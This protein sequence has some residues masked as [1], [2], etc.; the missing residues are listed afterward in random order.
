MT[1]QIQYRFALV[2]L[3]VQMIY[4]EHGADIVGAFK[5]SDFNTEFGKYAANRMKWPQYTCLTFS[6]R[7]DARA[8]RSDDGQTLDV[9]TGG[10]M[11]VLLGRAAEDG[12]VTLPDDLKLLFEMNTQSLRSA[13][14]WTEEVLPF[15]MYGTPPDELP[16]GS[17]RRYS[18]AEERRGHNAATWE[19]I[20]SKVRRITPRH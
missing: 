14:S 4:I 2:S 17:R 9:S 20:A 15:L 6:G 3:P 19:L 18:V 13:E 16:E 5:A 7:T 1:S 11:N 12:G 8:L 10:L